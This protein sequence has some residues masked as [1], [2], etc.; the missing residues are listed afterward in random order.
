MEICTLFSAS[1]KLPQS[2]TGFDSKHNLNEAA[3]GTGPTN[4]SSANAGPASASYS[5]MEI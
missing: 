5:G 4:P 3:S 1:E 2:T